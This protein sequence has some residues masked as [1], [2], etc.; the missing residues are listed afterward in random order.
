M[1]PIGAVASFL[2]ISKSAY[3]LGKYIHN[4]YEGAKRIDENVRS[5]ASEVNGLADS[6]K[7][8]HDELH[9]VLT[10][11]PSGVAGTLYDNDG[12]LGR[13]VDQQVVQCDSTLSELRRV[14]DVLWPRNGTLYE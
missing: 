12:R 2:Q 9:A 1:D 5:L 13:C 14:V 10:R 11:S 8:V 4:V 3:A 6:C 7:L